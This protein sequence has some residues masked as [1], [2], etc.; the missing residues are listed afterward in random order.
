MISRI[1]TKADIPGIQSLQQRYLYSELTPEGRLE[2]FVTTPFTFEQ[3][4]KSIESSGLFVSEYKT[5]IVAYAFAGTW[6]FFEQWPIFPYMTSRFP[7]LSYKDFEITVSSTFQYGPVCV[8]KAWRG[9]GTFIQVFESM[10]L[11]W[12]KSFAL[13][14]TFINAINTVSSKAHQKLGWEIIDHFTFNDKQ[15]LGLA[16]DMNHSVL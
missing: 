6:E 4:T 8:D 11:E 3:I 1:A 10:R 13:S 14:I 12:M 2:G 16:F 5:E 9:K 7:Q 15:Y